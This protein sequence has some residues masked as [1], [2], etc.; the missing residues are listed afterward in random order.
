AGTA[1]VADHFDRNG[2]GAT[3]YKEALEAF[4]SAAA[5]R[6]EATIHY[7]IAG[8]VLRDAPDPELVRSA[9]D[10]TDRGLRWA[11]DDQLLI[12]AKVNLLLQEHRLTDSF[13][14][15]DAA[16]P[17]LE[18]TLARDQTN[19]E[20]Y[21][22]LGTL[23]YYRGDFDSAEENWRRAAGLMPHR[24]APQRNLAILAEERAG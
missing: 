12:T 19:G 13:E 20:F 6:P 7:F 2:L 15:L 3:S 5:L 24:E 9:I 23:F 22:K 1:L 14:P 10:L 16:Q 11:P 4:E 18:E 8:S 17:L 21:L